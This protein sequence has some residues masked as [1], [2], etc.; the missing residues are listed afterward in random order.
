MLFLMLSHYVDILL[1]II[2][3]KSIMNFSLDDPFIQ[4][5]LLKEII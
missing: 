3:G 2:N 4:K 5:N 1:E